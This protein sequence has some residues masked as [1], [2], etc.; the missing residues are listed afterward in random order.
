[1]YTFWFNCELILTLNNNAARDL[2]WELFAQFIYIHFWT[3]NEPIAHKVKCKAIRL[4]DWWCCLILNPWHRFFFLN[5]VS[6]MD[7]LQCLPYLWPYQTGNSNLQCA[8]TLLWTSFGGCKNRLE[9]ERRNWV[10]QQA[11]LLSIWLF[12]FFPWFISWFWTHYLTLHP[13]LW[14]EEVP[15]DHFWWWEHMIFCVLG[16]AIVFERERERER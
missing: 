14:E 16:S 11:I 3:L 4:T 6:H 12:F 10:Y 8:S 5:G 9:N 13:L 15:I 1:M 7:R 2:V